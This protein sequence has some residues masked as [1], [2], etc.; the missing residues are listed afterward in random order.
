MKR[1]AFELWNLEVG[2]KGE[3]RTIRGWRGC[4]IATDC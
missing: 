3:D 4:A 1:R 2:V